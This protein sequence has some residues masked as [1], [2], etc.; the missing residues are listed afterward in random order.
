MYKFVASETCKWRVNC[1]LLV[2]LVP[3]L[4]LSPLNVDMFFTQ[5]V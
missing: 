1:I 5:T 3:M 2:H 4:A